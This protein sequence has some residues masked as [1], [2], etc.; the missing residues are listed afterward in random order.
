MFNSSF[1]LGKLVLLGNPGTSPEKGSK[2]GLS[3]KGAVVSFPG[4]RGEG[5]RWKH[6][7]FLLLCATLDCKFLVIKLFIYFSR[8]KIV[9]TI[10]VNSTHQD[11]YIIEN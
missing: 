2:E 11:G 10:T 5:T 4:H 7:A 9:I 6:M 3:Y 1:G 8:H